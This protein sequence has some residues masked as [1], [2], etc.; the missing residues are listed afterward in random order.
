M[1]VALDSSIYAGAGRYLLTHCSFLTLTCFY[2][3]ELSAGLVEG[4]PW[5]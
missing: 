2:F 1:V 4:I 5:V 3:R